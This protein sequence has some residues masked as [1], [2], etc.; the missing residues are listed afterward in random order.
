MMKATARHPLALLPP[1]P[2][3]SP[4]ARPLAPCRRCRL[5]EAMGGASDRPPSHILRTGR[6]LQLGQKITVVVSPT[7]YPTCV[8]RWIAGIS[9]CTGRS[10]RKIKQAITA[11]ASS[12][13]TQLLPAGF[14]LHHVRT[15]WAG[16][17]G[18]S[19]S[20]GTR[21]QRMRGSCSWGNAPSIDV[22]K[23]AVRRASQR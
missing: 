13:F 16:S 9:I 19:C 1:P 14:F 5:P 4:T 10:W 17:L 11:F 21:K 3:A 18:G 23:S 12:G 20:V 7:L 6:L 8:R 2:A 22:W 15:C